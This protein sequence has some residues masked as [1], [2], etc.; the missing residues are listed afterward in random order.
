MGDFDSVWAPGVAVLGIDIAGGLQGLRTAAIDPQKF[1]YNP[2]QHAGMRSN[3]TQFPA[4]FALLCILVI[5][6][7]RKTKKRPFERLRNYGDGEGFDEC[8]INCSLSSV[9]IATSDAS[10]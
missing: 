5:K 4:G 9:C 7:A 2:C 3:Q 6:A 8:E 10:G 1:S